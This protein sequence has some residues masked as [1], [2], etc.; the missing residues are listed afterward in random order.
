[1]SKRKLRVLGVLPGAANLKPILKEFSAKGSGIVTSLS[2]AKLRCIRNVYPLEQNLEV[3]QFGLV[4]GKIMQLAELPVLGLANAGQ[5]RAAIAAACRNLPEDSAYAKSSMFPGAQRRILATLDE[6]RQW[7]IDVASLELCASSV[8]G[9]LR[10]KLES[11]IHVERELAES[12]GRLGATRNVDRLESCIASD[13]RIQ[14]KLRLL[15]IAES[16]VDPIH[17]DW[18]EWCV[19]S[20]AELTLVL[21]S[22]PPGSQA[23]SNAS[24]IAKK[25]NVP[26]ENRG[27]PNVLQARL[28]TT[29]HADGRPI[30]VSIRSVSDTLSECEWA[31]RS[32]I[33]RL[34]AGAAPESI[35]VCTRDPESY[36]PLLEASAARL[37]L[38]LSTA[39]RVPLL[40]NSFAKVML[41]VLEACASTDCR[42]LSGLA[43]STYFATTVS[44][45][46]ALVEAAANAYRHG[47]DQWPVLDDWVRNAT[48]SAPWLNPIL[49]WR[50]RYGQGAATLS[51]WLDRLREF[52]QQEWHQAAL[53]PRSEMSE[54]DSYAQSALLRSLAQHASVERVRS[55]SKL[56]LGAF[57]VACRLVWD[58][59]DVSTPSFAN[60]VTVASSPAEIGD[61]DVLYVLGML[62]GIFPRRRTED[63]V[64]TDEERRNLSTTQPGSPKLRDSHDKAAAERDVFYRLCGTP[65][66]TLVFSYPQTEED[67]DNVRAFYLSEIERVL[68]G[69]FEVE[70]FPR[71]ML[72]PAQPLAEAD[73]RLSLALSSPREPPLPN[74]LQSAS[75]KEELSRAGSLPISVRELADE[76][77]CPFHYFAR[78]FLE[79]RPNLQ[80]SF[81]TSLYRLPEEVCLPA[82]E[83]P[84]SARTAL[85]G[86]LDRL[87]ARLLG[88]AEPH[89]LALMRSGGRRLIEDW[90][91]REFN[92]RKVWPRR[93]VNK[94]PSYEDGD[95]RQRVLSEEGDILLKGRLPAISLSNG[96]RMLHLFRR[97]ELQEMQGFQRPH[98]D[99][100]GRALKGRDRFEIGL[101]LLTLGKPRAAVGIEVDS[102]SGGRTMFLTP[103]P[104]GQMS[105]ADMGGMRVSPISEPN[106]KRLR[107]E[108]V[109]KI[110]L[111]MRR[112]RTA[113]IEATPGEHCATCECGELCRRSSSFSEE[114]DPF[115]VR[116]E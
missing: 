90:V 36:V 53:D 77:D 96:Y 16:Q 105:K 27:D 54:R 76:L 46:K 69:K 116:D 7:R 65:R 8:S 29:E 74:V 78:H 92:A 72:V 59:S 13:A 41:Q 45:G 4:V 23:F 93:E 26:L 6:L 68:D 12:L 31:L 37:G 109:E 101:Y 25:L 71:S 115:E 14:G 114:S 84:E 73:V 97:A 62:E 103:P 49:D 110:N 107:E 20:G 108:I 51:D 111:A 87:L 81:W 106:W 48:D 50:R 94:A 64:L 70:H 30:E 104:T 15:L 100:F 75:V 57:V 33:E 3:D 67:R 88:V 61:V 112:I 21:D 24:G 89:V 38:R 10:S 11:L 39:R 18:I 102:T 98:E 79:L 42:L 82:L 58:D 91:S 83:S 19:K 2:D 34:S 80:R 1:M 43:S 55:G 86:A 22:G 9:G 47:E 5:V 56:D 63:P 60:G 113:K 35:A 85:R 40:S 99:V 95:L 17:L 52:G 28:F 44:Q 32:V 66:S